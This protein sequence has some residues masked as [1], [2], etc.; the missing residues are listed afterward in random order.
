MSQLTDTLIKIGAPVLKTMLDVGVGGIGA[1]LGDAAID[2]LAEALGT[3]ADPDAIN[4]AINADP[5]TT[6]PIV[7]NVEA[8]VSSNMARIA[9]ANQQVMIGYQQ[10][11]LAD[12]KAEG[13][14][15]QR[16]RP[17]FALIFSLCFLA[18][19]VTICHLVW[20]KDVGVITAA[21]DLGGLLIAMFTVGAAV[22]G[23]YV[24]Q[25]SEEKKAGV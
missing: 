23:V 19:V 4:N 15:A 11:L 10:I 5:A 16:W 7:Q 14:L 13:W 25:R 21:S 3:T 22:L 24:W 2:A 20:D 6:T 8:E 9:E 18:V 1:K 17:I 12:Q